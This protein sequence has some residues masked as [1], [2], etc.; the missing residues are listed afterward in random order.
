MNGVSGSD[1][2]YVVLYVSCVA[3]WW[4]VLCLMGRCHASAIDDGP[5]FAVVVV[6]SHWYGDWRVEFVSIQ[7]Y[8][9]RFGFR[10]IWLMQHLSFLYFDFR[11]G[12][13]SKPVCV[14]GVVDIRSCKLQ[15]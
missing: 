7:Y 15:L 3:W 2:S 8:V 11:K 14:F 5:D 9:L 4:E 13:T 1:V 10:R 12:E 6:G